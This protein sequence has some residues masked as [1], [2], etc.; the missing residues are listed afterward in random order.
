M[1]LTSDLLKDL[2]EQEGSPCNSP[3]NANTIPS[4]SLLEFLKRLH[5]YTK[6]S[7]ECLVIAI[8]YIDRYNLELEDFRLNHF[9]V[10]KMVLVA[11]LL[12]AKFQDDIYYD[13]KA[14]E[15]AGGVNAMHLHQL[16]L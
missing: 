4:M 9:N 5:K 15:F 7:A 2:I 3:F 14:Y 12:A 11:L 13:N 16:E 10:Y 1:V 8:I 6:Y